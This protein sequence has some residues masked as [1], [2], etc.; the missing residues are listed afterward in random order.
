MTT[1][2]HDPIDY[3][4]QRQARDHYRAV[5]KLIGE[6]D[7]KVLD[8]LLTALNTG[9]TC[10]WE[11]LPEAIQ[12]GLGLLGDIVMPEGIGTSDETFDRLMDEHEA[13]AKAQAS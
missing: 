12:E 11:D 8:A 7:I 1:M 13:Q 4:D 9:L 10:D 5:N 2:N 3:E 6:E